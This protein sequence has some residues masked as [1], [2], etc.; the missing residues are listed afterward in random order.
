MVVGFCEG[1]DGTTQCDLQMGW[2]QSAVSEVSGELQTPRYV[3]GLRLD[4][5]PPLQLQ[6]HTK[7][8]LAS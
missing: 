5:P 2:L 6:G 7:Q 1:A 8:V 4:Y 3:V